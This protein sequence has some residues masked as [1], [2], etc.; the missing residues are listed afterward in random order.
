MD[1]PHR[2]FGDGRLRSST[3][4]PAQAATT[5]TFPFHRSDGL[6]RCMLEAFV[7]TLGLIRLY[8]SALQKNAIFFF[9]EEWYTDE[10]K[11]DGPVA[12]SITVAPRRT[13]MLEDPLAG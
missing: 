3:A 7:S 2:S 1:D 8:A 6:R 11:K 13:L 12:T 4:V 10:D 5:A 9:D